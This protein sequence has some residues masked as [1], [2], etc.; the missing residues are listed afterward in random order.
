MTNQTI[1]LNGKTYELTNILSSI[2]NNPVVYLRELPSSPLKEEFPKVFEIKRIF[3][4]PN[5]L[6]FDIKPI[7]EL[8]DRYVIDGK[9]WIDPFANN[10]ERTEYSNDLNPDCKTKYHLDAFE[11]VEQLEGK[12]HG[13]LFDP[14]YS[15]HQT[16][17]M[18]KGYGLRKQVSVIMDILSNK[19]EVG[20]FAISFG[21]STNGFGKSR[22]FEIVEILLVAHGGSHNDTTC[23][24]ERKVDYAEKIRGESK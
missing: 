3:A 15:M 12:Y 16:N 22:G 6:T 4:M 23:V 19:I 17:Q 1:T 9:G 7:K 10:S 8:L 21:W 24:V 20:G 18:Y 14:P 5:H 2:N 11:F 13:V